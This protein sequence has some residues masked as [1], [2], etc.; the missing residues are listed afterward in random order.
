[1]KGLHM[2]TFLILVA[3]GLNWF[4]EAF[5][6]GIGIY[7]SETV[8]QI[9]YIIIGLSAVFELATHK[10]NCKACSASGTPVTPVS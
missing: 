5:G 10:G 7:V 2:V 8:A 9:I 1:M 3:G 6:Y 4:L